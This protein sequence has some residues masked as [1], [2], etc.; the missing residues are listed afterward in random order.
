MN[1]EDRNT[2]V[3]QLQRIEQIMRTLSGV[4]ETILYEINQPGSDS[5][6]LEN[7]L[8]HMEQNLRVIT[9]AHHIILHEIRNFDTRPETHR[10]QMIRIVVRNLETDLGAD[11]LA[12]NEPEPVGNRQKIINKVKALTKAQC[13]IEL[14]SCG[15]CLQNHTVMETITCQC[16]HSFGKS[17]FENW[18][19]VCH[20]NNKDATCPT[21]RT[22]VTQTTTY[23][24]RIKKEQGPAD[25]AIVP[26]P[27][28]IIDEVQE[29]GLPALYEFEGM[30]SL[31]P[32]NVVP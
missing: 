6:T 32:L 8:H 30:P 3:S 12:V 5:F 17:C 20:N 10:Q 4:R 13:K 23:R 9:Q 2:L 19:N 24:R 27:L 31:T 16:D 28:T 26:N 18:R 7:H 21:C 22:K 29:E 25:A 11:L 15:I 1:S 14:E